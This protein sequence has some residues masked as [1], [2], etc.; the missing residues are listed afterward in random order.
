MGKEAGVTRIFISYAWVFCMHM[1]LQHG[2]A[3][4]PQRPGSVIGPPGTRVVFLTINE[5]FSSDILMTQIFNIILIIAHQSV[6]V[7]HGFT[8]K[9]KLKSSHKIYCVLYFISAWNSLFW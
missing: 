7:E 6:V 4:C 3:W 5:I 1:R 2:S 8:D 9:Y